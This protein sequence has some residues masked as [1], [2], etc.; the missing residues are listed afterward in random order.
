MTATWYKS[1]FFKGGLY[2]QFLIVPPF[3][4]GGLGGIYGSQGSEKTFGNRNKSALKKVLSLRRVP[5]SHQEW[6]VR[7]ALRGLVMV[8]KTH[9]TFQTNPPSTN[10]EL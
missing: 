5:L 1:P 6:R 2:K 9:P 3:I 10:P 8:R 7:R 4:K